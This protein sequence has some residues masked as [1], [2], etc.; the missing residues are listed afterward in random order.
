MASESPLHAKWHQNHH[1]VTPRQ[2][3]PVTK[4]LP[5][6]KW[7]QSHRRPVPWQADYSRV[8]FELAIFVFDNTLA[9]CS[10]AHTAARDSIAVK[11]PQLRRYRS[12]NNKISRAYDIF[13]Q[14]MSQ[15]FWHAF[16]DQVTNVGYCGRFVIS[17]NL[18]VLMI[19]NPE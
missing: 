3:A 11:F 7:H 18:M 14:M 10:F 19:L 8:I 15:S 17:I 5:C 13:E 16:S 6:A 2:M 1:R 9:M 4:E 12:V